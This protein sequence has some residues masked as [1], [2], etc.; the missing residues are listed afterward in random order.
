MEKILRE[1][2]AEDRNL[3]LH[4][5]E[6]IAVLE[7]KV[8]S[9]LLREFSAI[10]FA[11]K[12]NVGNFFVADRENFI[13]RY[14][15]IKILIESG[16]SEQKINFVLKIFSRALMTDDE[17]KEIFRLKDR[18]AELESKIELPARKFFW[19]CDKLFIFKN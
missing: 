14:H 5:Q 3:L 1:V 6:L 11:L 8:P 9:N 13:G 15:A 4:P 16:M 19:D 7:K 12:F 10:K 18:I 17:S 2:L